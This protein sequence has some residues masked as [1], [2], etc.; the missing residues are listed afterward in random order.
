MDFDDFFDGLFFAE[1]GKVGAEADT[2]IGLV[3]GGEGG[4]EVGKHFGAW[5]KGFQGG[6]DALGLVVEGG[7]GKDAGNVFDGTLTEG[8]VQ[9]AVDAVP[10]GEGSLQDGG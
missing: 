4:G 3:G 9:E 5:T 8:V 2:V 7:V 1:E 10:Q 6:A